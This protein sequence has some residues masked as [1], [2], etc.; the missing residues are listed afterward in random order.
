MKLLKVA[1]IASA[2]ILAG[3]SPKV[4]DT[5]IQDGYRFTTFEEKCSNQKILAWA[6]E[7]GASDKQV[8]DLKSAQVEV[9]ETKQKLKACVLYVEGKNSFILV[10]EELNFGVIINPKDIPAKK[11]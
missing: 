2:L 10:D 4:K 11:D 6:K 9:L 3:C 8:K 5:F 7:T 1:V